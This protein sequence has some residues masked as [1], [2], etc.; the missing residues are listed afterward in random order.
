MLVASLALLVT[1]C[2][3]DIFPVEGVVTLDGKPLPNGYIAFVPDGWAGGRGSASQITDGRYRVTAKRGK[4]VV[5]ITADRTEGIET[6]QYL[7]DK[8]N[9]QTTLKTEV[10]VSGPLDFDLKS[11]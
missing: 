5:M 3:E 4:Y 6:K 10:P 11:K 8:Y 1:S 2:G 7:P 9:D